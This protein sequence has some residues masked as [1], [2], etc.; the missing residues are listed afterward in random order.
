MSVDVASRPPRATPAHA[1]ERVH[2]GLFWLAII[3]VVI[4]A[5][6]VGGSR[7]WASKASS[8][9]TFPAFDQ[10]AVMS[11]SATLH[12]DPETLVPLQTPTTKSFLDVRRIQTPGLLDHQ[13]QLVSTDA[14]TL[15]GVK[16][17]VVMAQYLVDD[18]TLKNLRRPEAWSFV[19]TDV[20][21]RSSAYSVNLPFDTGAGP[22]DIW[23]NEADRAYTVRQVGQPFL[24]DGITVIRLQGHLDPT[25]VDPA[26]ITELS[27]AGF[28]AGATL[29]QLRAAVTALGVPVD[30]SFPAMPASLSVSD[31]ATM[32]DPVPLDYTMTA[33]ASLLVEPRTGTIVSVEKMD[34][35]YSARLDA[36]HLGTLMTVLKQHSASPG[37]AAA[38]AAA[39]KLAAVPAGPAFDLSYAQT[40]A[41][42][43]AMSSYAGGQRD[44]VNRMTR[45]IPTTMLAGGLGIVALGALA[46]VVA[47][48]RR[49]D[50]RAYWWEQEEVEE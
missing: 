18:R 40:S 48:R 13:A 17:T 32:L 38:L 43:K 19:G 47:W 49:N 45:T 15:D 25:P 26:Y 34:Q 8:L 5:L 2:T 16:T 39:T 12:I 50:V 27:R 36:A 44:S 46:G 42:V 9:V 11:G 21:D 7:A 31:V 4:G 10:Q 33:D 3:A 30:S 1:E 35:A 41:S 22:Y 28:P 23:L 37:M 6:L 29:H 14:I 24:A 20:A